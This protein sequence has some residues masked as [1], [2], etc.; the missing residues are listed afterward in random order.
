MDGR[1]DSWDGWL[2]MVVGSL[3]SP[4]VLKMRVGRERKS[5]C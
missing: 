3:R 2:S 1:I 5:A 4:S